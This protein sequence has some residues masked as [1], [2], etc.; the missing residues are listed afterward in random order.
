RAVPVEDDGPARRR[1]RPH[2]DRRLD[3]SA[4]G[5]DRGR[6]AVREDRARA[7]DRGKHRGHWTAAPVAAI[8]AVGAVSAVAALA[9]VGTASTLAPLAAVGAAAAV[10]ALAPF[11]AAARSRRRSARR[12]ACGGPARGAAGGTPARRATR[13]RPSRGAPGRRAAR[14]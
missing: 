2:P 10:P 11:G 4:A 14:A 1:G 12:A 8:A 6:S 5:V 3:A 13:R 9:A 7:R